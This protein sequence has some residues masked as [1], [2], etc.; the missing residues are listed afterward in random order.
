MKKGILIIG[1]IIAFIIPGIAQADLKT[2]LD[3]TITEFYSQ[4]KGVQLTLPAMNGFS[5]SVNK[6]FADAVKKKGADVKNLQIIASNIQRL[7]SIFYKETKMNRVNAFSIKGLLVTVDDLFKA[8]AL[9]LEKA[10]KKLANASAVKKDQS[11]IDEIDKG[12]DQNK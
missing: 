2:D 8:N 4:S 9:E 5:V 12:K 1:L 11:G 10:K 6:V 7:L 3:K